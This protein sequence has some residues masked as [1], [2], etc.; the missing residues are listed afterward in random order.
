MKHS[1]IILKP[2]V[3][4][5][6]TMLRENYNKYTFIVHKDANKIEISNAIKKMFDVTPLGINVINVSGKKKRLR[7]RY[8]YTASYKKAIVALKKGD[9]IAV[10]EG[11]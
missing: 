11:A 6:S 9:K 5:K 8:G 2:I 4:E 7:Y 3:T 1:D 10:F